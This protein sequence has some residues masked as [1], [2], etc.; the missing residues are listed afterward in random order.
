MDSPDSEILDAS[1]RR[2]IRHQHYY[3]EN[4]ARLREYSRQYQKTHRVRLNAK[5]RA[6][7]DEATRTRKGNYYRRNRERLLKQKRDYYV[8]T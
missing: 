4:K 8:R 6:H 7:Y 5:K 3:A 1:A 2:R